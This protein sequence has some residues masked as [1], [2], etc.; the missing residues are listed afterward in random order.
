MAAAKYS[1]DVLLFTAQDCIISGR[2]LV[3]WSLYCI[4][5]RFKMTDGVRTHKEKCYI[6]TKIHVACFLAVLEWW[7]QS[8]LA[9]NLSEGALEPSLRQSTCRPNITSGS[10][11]MLFFLFDILCSIWIGQFITVSAP[12]TATCG[13][14]I[15]AQSSYS[16][17]VYNWH[18]KTWLIGY[19]NIL[20][21]GVSRFLANL[22]SV[23]DI[24]TPFVMC[25]VFLLSLC[26]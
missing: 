24:Y 3:A 23:I 22:C 11:S 17:S 20:F 5:P 14:G 26:P 8:V 16:F 18:T 12:D 9:L 13:K 4:N 19:Y 10:V 15:A 6:S 25:G 7:F 1:D 2:A 21:L